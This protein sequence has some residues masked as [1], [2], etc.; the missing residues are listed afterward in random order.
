MGGLAT[1][2]FANCSNRSNERATQAST[3]SRCGY[4]QP[5]HK[6]NTPHCTDRATNASIFT[7]SRLRVLTPTTSATALQS[8]RTTLLAPT[9]GALGVSLITRITLPAPTH[10]TLGVFEFVRLITAAFDEITS[11]RC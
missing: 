5:T 6:L 3:D 2:A 8:Q 4:Y 7:V 9:H 11:M 10:G 1:V